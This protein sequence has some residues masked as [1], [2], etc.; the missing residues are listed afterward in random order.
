[1]ALMFLGCLDTRV[2]QITSS[3]KELKNNI[4]ILLIIHLCSPILIFI[5]KN[6]FTDEIFL[7]LILASV[8][9]SGMSIVF[10]SQLYGGSASKA[11]IINALSHS[12]SPVVIPFLVYLFAKK[13]IEINFL[14]MGIT[15]FKMVVLPYI[16]AIFIRKTPLYR[17]LKE[18]RLYISIF[19][20]Y[21]LVWGVIAPVRDNI[22]SD[23]GLSLYLFLFVS[24][25]V[26]L[27][28]LLGYLFGRGK[29]EKI[30]FAL[31][32]SYKCYTLS[33]VLALSLFGP[34]VALPSVIYT[35][36]NNL[37][38]I[39]LQVFISGKKQNM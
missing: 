33:T 34:V 15:I 35:V 20:L 36:V 25:L 5:F 11:L 39:P 12:F 14:E 19:A 2:R 23:L 38:L 32:A 1:M 28:F 24:G 16:A 4:L 29:K 31:S 30:T 10:L 9:S 6:R 22:L 26:A 13:T 27:N 17:P 7:G 21:L 8:M 3:L 37:Q 18:N